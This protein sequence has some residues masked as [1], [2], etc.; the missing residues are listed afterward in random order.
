MTEN[1]RQRAIAF[2]RSL[3]DRTSARREPFDGGVAT[4]TDVLPRIANLNLR[5][6]DEL[7]ERLPV[8]ELRAEAERLSAEG[9]R[10]CSG[11]GHRRVVSYDEEIGTRL[12]LGF[13]TLPGWT[14]ERV[15]L[16]AQHRPADRDVDTTF[17]RQVDEDELQPARERFFRG[18]GADDGLV[19]QELAAAR[20][21]ADLGDVWG[22]AA[23]VGDEV[24]SYC[25]LYADGSG[26]A[27]IRGVATLAE[28]RGGGLAR[29]TVSRAIAKSQAVGQEL[30]FL[31]AVHDDWPKNLYGKLGFDAIGM[32]FRFTRWV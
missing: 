11:L 25:E 32:M 31:R 19:A 4:L 14:T 5:R 1:E 13:E 15:V 2:M 27:Q 16:M 24:G 22:F 9:D 8:A 21:L 10:L 6:V 17:V 28:H 18:R 26:T 20:R 23:F 29:A 3:D 30:T 7:R 12:A